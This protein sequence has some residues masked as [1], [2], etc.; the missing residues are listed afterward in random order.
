MT[1][2]FEPEVDASSATL[3]AIWT[4]KHVQALNQAKLA[5]LY[6]LYSSVASTIHNL[7]RRHRATLLHSYVL[8]MPS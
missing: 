6:C 5:S 3:Q 2:R 8:V 1:L 7:Q 4:L